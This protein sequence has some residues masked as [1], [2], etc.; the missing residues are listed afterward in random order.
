VPSVA[1]VDETGTFRAQAFL[2]ASHAA[3][4]RW[5]DN[6]VQRCGNWV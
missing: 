1:Y 6:P 3:L 5:L 4:F 2:H